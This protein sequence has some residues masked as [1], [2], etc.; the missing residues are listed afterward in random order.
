MWIHTECSFI[1]DAEYG[2][3]E[4]SICSWICPKYK[5]LNFSDFFFSE[6][7]EVE[8]QN[9]FEPLS[10][11]KGNKSPTPDTTKPSV[12]KWLKVGNIN[13]NSIRGKILEP[14]AFLDA[15]QPQVAA[16]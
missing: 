15:H 14:L 4:N 9:R 5:V 6:L 1:S 8:N 7:I 16:I 2:T 11:E 12:V 13:I 3:L 10:R